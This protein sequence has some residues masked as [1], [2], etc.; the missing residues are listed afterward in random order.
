MDD[1]L[2]VILDNTAFGDETDIGSRYA[3]WPFLRTAID[4]DIPIQGFVFDG[5]IAAG[6][7]YCAINFHIGDGNIFEVAVIYLFNVCL[8]F[9]IRQINTRLDLFLQFRCQLDG[10][11]SV[12]FECIVHQKLRCLSVVFTINL[13]EGRFVLS[14]IDFVDFCVSFGNIWRNDI[15]VIV[16]D[17]AP[18]LTH[19][20]IVQ[21][22]IGVGFICDGDVRG[23]IGVQFTC[24]GQV[25]GLHID[26]STTGGDI[27]NIYIENRTAGA[28]I[29]NVAVC[30]CLR[31]PQFYHLA[32]YSPS[33]QDIGLHLAVI[34]A[35]L[36]SIV[37]GYQFVQLIQPFAQSVG[38]VK[39]TH[40]YAILHLLVGQVGVRLD[41]EPIRYGAFDG[42]IDG[43]GSARNE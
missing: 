38:I 6:I 19:D 9:L 34:Y 37:G 8:L 11:L 42:H 2:L 10:A 43:I 26:I 14:F 13:T 16:N 3:C 35:I 4:V 31:E 27:R 23:C 30:I 24:A 21:S 22:Q 20:D 18:L 12:A 36:F 29:Y 32:L 7:A 17:L 1:A 41:F 40:C 5:H 15:I 33:L 28:D 25:I 39:S